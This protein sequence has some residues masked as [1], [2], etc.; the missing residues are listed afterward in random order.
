LGSPASGDSMGTAWRRR[1]SAVAFGKSIQQWR[2]HVFA[3]VTL[4]LFHG[5][6][7]FLAR[8]TPR[9]HDLMFRAHERGQIVA[10]NFVLFFTTSQCRGGVAEEQ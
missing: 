3:E 8:R 10:L 1:D 7:M 2:Q 5:I 6:E 9:L 4:K